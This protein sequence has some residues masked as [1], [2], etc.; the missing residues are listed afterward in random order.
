VGE[1]KAGNDTSSRD[2]G[3]FAGSAPKVKLKLNVRK[4]WGKR[5]NRGIDD[6]KGVENGEAR[7]M[8]AASKIEFR[9]PEKK[10][11]MS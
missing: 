3:G 11:C 2:A 6:K 9:V 4:A 5:K 7:A 10:A 8:W 1:K